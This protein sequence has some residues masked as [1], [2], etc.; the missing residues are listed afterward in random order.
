MATVEEIDAFIVQRDEKIAL[1]EA[2]RAEAEKEISIEEGSEA[3]PAD[4]TSS[5][6]ELEEAVP[7][8]PIVYDKG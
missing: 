4:E 1:Q 8:P 6:T 2:A 3:G 7:E 5:E